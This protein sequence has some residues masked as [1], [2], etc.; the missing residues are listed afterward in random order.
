MRSRTT[1]LLAALVTAATL[2]PGVAAA[3]VD[4]VACGD[5]L[6]TDTVLTR[7]LTC[8]G[9]D[10]LTLLGG[11]TLD[12]GGHTL[13]G[14]GAGSGTAVRVDPE[15]ESAITVHNGAIEH[16]GQ[17]L[18]A[19]AVLSADVERVR[20]AHLGNAL[21]TFLGT[22]TIDASRFVDIGVAVGVSEGEAVIT[23]SEFVDNGRAVSYWSSGTASVT[24]D[25]SSFV[26]NGVALEC[27]DSGLRVTDSV[28]RSNDSAVRATWC[29]VDVA[30]STF[31]RND[32][33]IRTSPGASLQGGFA[34]S[35]VDST[36]TDNGVAAYLGTSMD[37]LRSTFTR[38]A[39]ALRSPVATEPTFTVT[40]ERS[41][42]KR[43]GDAVH[44]ESPSRVGRNVV[45]KNT[46]YGIY[47]PLAMDL[48][49]NVAAGN[50]VEPQCTGVVC[51]RS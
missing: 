47:A 3:A 17:G 39:T 49:G 21:S 12:L 35:V 41:S 38:N 7:D 44:L 51:R 22:L 6:T 50:G 20:F 13:T 37:V 32:E 4:T 9:G 33:G 34:G 2:Q 15:T 43:N 29:G 11:V 48:G 24:V 23:D 46:G 36:F 28:F 30:G 42:F 18:S 14:P 5:T 19:D 8:A 31:A 40:V 16:W 27:D 45:L 26:R 1:I 10:G 25:G